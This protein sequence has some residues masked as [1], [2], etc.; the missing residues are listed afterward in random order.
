MLSQRGR[1]CSGRVPAIGGQNGHRVGVSRRARD[2]VRRALRRIWLPAELQRWQRFE[3]AVLAI[4]A[5]TQIERALA[6]IAREGVLLTGARYGALGVAD[7]NLRIIRFV[8]FG[9]PLAMEQAIGHLPEGRGLLG[10]LLREQ[11]PLRVDNIATHP[12]AAGFPPGHLPMRSF[13]GTPIQLRGRSVGN[14]YLTDKD[15]GKPFTDDDER[16]LRM[17]A[18][19]AAVAIENARLLDEV[20]NRAEELETLI[21]T[22]RE[23][24]VA[25]NAAGVVTICNQRATALLGARQ[26]ETHEMV[27]RRVVSLGGVPPVPEIWPTT[28]ALEGGHARGVEL[29]V[30]SEHGEL[31]LEGFAAPLAS[32]DGRTSGALLVVRDVTALRRLDRAKDDFL[33]VASHDLQHPFNVVKLYSSLLLRALDAGDLETGRD[34]AQTMAEEAVSGARLVD[35]LLDASRIQV[36][37]FSIEREMLDLGPAVA[38][39]VE[40]WQTANPETA[41]VVRVPDE[42][43]PVV[44]DPDRLSELIGNLLGNAAKYAPGGRVEVTVTVEG[45]EATLW[46]RD[47]GPGVPETDQPFIFERFYRSPHATHRKGTGLG[48]YVCRGIAEAHGGRLRYED[49]P[50]GGALF[51]V[52]L[53]LAIPARRGGRTAASR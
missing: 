51:V 8:T 4:S 50:G 1:L 18:S 28:T 30:S 22:M 38:T 6:A 45:D 46:V 37:R 14:L 15:G 24:V 13:L 35:K 16:M 44:G 34:A 48:L 33:A 17:L 20:H 39:A 2:A 7:E 10:L 5:E 43:V 40:E 9:A 19:H 12:A 49:P 29:L 42:R 52:S 21:S 41:V 31:L 26:G 25:V 3:R 32:H 53:P 27:Y 11:R 47:H 36:G 23:G